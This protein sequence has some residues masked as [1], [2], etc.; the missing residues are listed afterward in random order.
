MIF[1]QAS[2]M[3]SIIFVMSLVV[4][5]CATNAVQKEVIATKKA[6]EA[7]GPYSQAVNFGNLLFAGQIAIDPKTNQLM[8]DARHRR[9]DA[10]GS[11]QPQSSA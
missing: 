3:A 4:F 1:A 11:E 5:G 10:A 6:P 9:S 8:K 2:K 7:I